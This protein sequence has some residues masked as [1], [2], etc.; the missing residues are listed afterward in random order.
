MNND[1]L[2]LVS[3]LMATY[4]YGN[5]ISKSINSVLL[6]TYKNI[7]C[8]VVDDGSTDDTQSVLSC[9]KDKRL[10]IFSQTNRGQAEAWNRAFEMSRGEY[11]FFCDADDFFFENKIESVLAH[12]DE[13]T[14]LYQHDLI[15]VDVQGVPI[16]SATFGAFTSK[17]GCPLRE[18]DLRLQLLQELGWYFAPSSGLMVP[19][20]VCGKIFPISPY[21]AVCAD[22]PVAYGASLLGKVKLIPLSLGVYRLHRNS[23]YSSAF[24]YDYRWLIEQYINVIQRYFFCLAFIKQGFVE[25]VI[26][27]G[28]K[29]TVIDPG[30]Q[31]TYLRHIEPNILIKF[32]Y[33]ARMRL[34][35]LFHFNA[36][37]QL[38]FLSVY[39]D[40]LSILFFYSKS[41][42][43]YR[44]GLQRR[45][46]NIIISVTRTHMHY[47]L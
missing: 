28:L 35:E 25:P 42:S 17:T 38:W 23:N 32:F 9:I 2:P 39:Q 1:S 47:L 46:L 11:I 45:G 15:E 18:G 40:A 30:M 44:F 37:R 3:V 12:I 20:A 26:V 8:I 34:S 31:V 10:K 29:F 19:R 22:V 4:N 33:L 14:T 6:Q 24:E 43:D 13:G 36:G 7:E 27:R 41:R 16:G 5:F 21:F